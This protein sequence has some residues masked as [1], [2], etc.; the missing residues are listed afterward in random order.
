MVLCCIPRAKIGIISRR[1]KRFILNEFELADTAMQLGYEVVLLPL[2]TMTYYEQVSVCFCI[3]VFVSLCLCVCIY[4]SVRLLTVSF[5]VFTRNACL[6]DVMLIGY[7]ILSVVV[8]GIIQVREFRSLDVLVGLH[9]SGLD[10]VSAD[11]A[12]RV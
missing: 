10:N 12:E 9:G 8:I 3:C 1:S 7:A 5:I 2:E 4:V 6:T 11:Q